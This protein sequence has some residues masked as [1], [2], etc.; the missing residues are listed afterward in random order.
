MKNATL[1][2]VISLGA[3]I[4]ID[5]IQIIMSFFD[6]YSIDLFRLFGV[7]NLIAFTG[8]LPFFVTLYNKQKE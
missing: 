7:L 4:L 6:F 1:L 5:L 2:A 8:L 3:I